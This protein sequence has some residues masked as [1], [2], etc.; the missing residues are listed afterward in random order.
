MPHD[1]AWAWTGLH[2]VDKGCVQSA[3]PLRNI[4]KGKDAVCQS[5]LG[6]HISVYSHPPPSHLLACQRRLHARLSQQPSQKPLMFV[7]ECQSSWRQ[8]YVGADLMHLT[9]KPSQQQS[10]PYLYVMSSRLP[11][12]VGATITAV[13]IVTIVTKTVTAVSDI[14]QYLMPSWPP[15]LVG[16]DQPH[17]TLSISFHLLKR[18][19]IAI[20]HL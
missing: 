7:S 17:I 8:T 20:R 10:I 1:R 6:Y 12:L 13:S 3:G 11:S 16:A 14:I 15:E 5:V 18:A 9:L 2:Y 4:F 19:T